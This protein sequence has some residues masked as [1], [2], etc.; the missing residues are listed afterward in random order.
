MPHPP[1]PRYIGRY[2]YILESLNS[3]DLSIKTF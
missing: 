1:T 3:K 2:L